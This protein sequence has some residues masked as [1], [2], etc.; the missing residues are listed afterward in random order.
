MAA[1][2]YFRFMLR[3]ILLSISCCFLV[4]SSFAQEKFSIQALKQPVEIITD[5]WG[6]PHIYAQNE[7]DLFFS[8]GFYAARDRLFQFEIWRRQATGTVA[9]I[10]GPREIDR[11]RGARLF[12]FRGNMDQE[13]A[14]YHPRGKT[15]VESFVAGVN[16]FI[17]ETEANPAL[18][19]PEF[20]M[21][22]IKPAYW[23]PW[24]V[25]SRHQGLLENLSDEWTNAKA[26]KAMGLEKFKQ[27]QWYHP[28]EPDLRLD[29]S[30]PD[31]LLEQDV[32]KFYSAFRKALEF[33]PEDLVADLRNLSYSD[34]ASL[35][36]QDVEA[37]EE[38]QKDRIATIGSNNWTVSGTLTQSGFPMLANDPHRVLSTPSLR[39]MAHLHAPGWN[40]VGAG[41]PVIPGI[42]I[43]H[44]EHGA[45]GLTIFAT[46]AEDLYVCQTDPN[47]PDQYFFQGT[48]RKMI[49]I[50]D[51]IKVKGAPTQYV[52]HKYTHHGPVLYENADLKVLCA[53][54]CAWLDVGGSPYLSS[55]RMDQ[56]KT[57]EEF[58]QACNYSHVPALN[59]IWAD[60][61]GNIGWQVVGIA[62]VRRKHSGLIP[63]PGDGRYEWEG[64]QPMLQRPNTHNPAS[65]FVATANENLTARNYPYPNS[66]GFK[67]A[68]P[69]RGDRV[70]EVLSSGRKHTL[71]DFMALQCDYTSIPARNLVPLLKELPQTDPEIEN[72]RQTLLKWDFV[73]DKNS[74]AASIYQTWETELLSQIKVLLIP[75]KIRSSLNPQV[76]RL[77]EWLKLP[78]GKFGENAIQ[79]RDEFVQKALQTAVK[80]LQDKL[81]ADQSKWIY[82]QAAFKHVSIRHPLSNAMKPELRNKFDHGPLPRGGNSQTVGNTGPNLNQTHGATF[83]MVVDTYLSIRTTATFSHSGPTTV[84]SRCSLAGKRSKA[85]VFHNCN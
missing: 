73:L 52:T 42:S 31:A 6:V 64:Y 34:Y 83:R 44:N 71:Q 43:G 14:H 61:K 50:R 58:R 29:P 24:V 60:R 37:N 85:S 67:W 41:E 4:K 66:I 57:W 40:V 38:V 74:T 39:Y 7:A 84:I 17:K 10:L 15:I 8:Q 32:L 3:S 45:W 47:R 77:I 76:Y 33:K 79:G 69:F 62:P 36:A 22:G 63:V 1:R 19:P 54:R 78:D 11:D 46:D 21:L 5:Q 68:D 53:V 75:E 20:A 35:A 48:W 28:N 49:L 13:L 59:M 56:A 81:G 82:G 72:A 80:K 2:G 30:I 70:S 23:T 25:V 16:A 27:L 65:G 9:E 51:S 55:L 26:I 18:L 12:Q